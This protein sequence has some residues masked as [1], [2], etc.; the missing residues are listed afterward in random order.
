MVTVQLDERI[1][2]AL[3]EQARARG[4]SLEAYL[5]AVAE[6]SQNTVTSA[7][8]HDNVAEFDTVL[9]EL[10]A[11]DTRSLPTVPLTYSRED[12]YSDHD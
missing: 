9:D 8:N 11:A 7:V 4:L 2:T 3:R 10:F 12:I 6:T 5:R 1:A